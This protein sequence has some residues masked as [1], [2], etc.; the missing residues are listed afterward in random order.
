MNVCII[1][2]IDM[3]VAWSAKLI[4]APIEH[5]KLSTNSSN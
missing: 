5:I 1:C 2:D 3:A 4:S